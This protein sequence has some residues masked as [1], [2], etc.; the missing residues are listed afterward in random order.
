MSP[1]NL[2]FA[3]LLGAILWIVLGCLI[4]LAATAD[5]FYLWAAVAAAC[6][7]LLTVALHIWLD[8]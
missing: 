1:L 7:G 8:R 5:P 4:A 3:L 6:G 2:L